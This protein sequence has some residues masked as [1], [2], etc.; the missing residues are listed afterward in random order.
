MIGQ[1][2]PASRLRALLAVASLEALIA[3][4]RD[5]ADTVMPIFGQELLEQAQAKGGVGRHPF[6]QTEMRRHA[7]YLPYL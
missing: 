4:N 7:G 1:P 5:N 3:F 2:N 6:A